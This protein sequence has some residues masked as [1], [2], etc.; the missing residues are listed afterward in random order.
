MHKGT[1]ALGL[2]TMTIRKEGQVTAEDQ[3]AL[4]LT[5]ETDHVVTQIKI[6]IKR[7]IT[8]VCTGSSSMFLFFTCSVSTHMG[9]AV[10]SILSLVPDFL[11]DKGITC[12]HVCTPSFLPS[13]D[14][15]LPNMD[16]VT[17]VS[18]AVCQWSSTHQLGSSY[19]APR[20]EPELCMIMEGRSTCIQAVHEHVPLCELSAV[21]KPQGLMPSL[22]RIRYTTRH[23][24]LKEHVYSD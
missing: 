9:Q 1:G 10:I 24:L 15:T 8:K 23:I 7:K 22:H 12:K 4:F 11:W 5:S 17:S 16:L 3:H 2:K 6:K 13:G 19:S 14:M 20:R 21:C 18:D